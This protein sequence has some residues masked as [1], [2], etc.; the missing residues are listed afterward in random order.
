MTSGVRNCYSFF[1]YGGRAKRSSI[2]VLEGDAALK[3][4][5]DMAYLWR[6]LLVD[7]GV[8]NSSFK[9]SIAKGYSK[10]P[11]V[12]M[13]CR[14][15]FFLQV[16]HSF[17][18]RWFWLSS[19]ANSLADHLSRG[20]ELEF[21]KE[22]ASSGFWS[23]GATEDPYTMRHP[24]AG[25]RRTLASL[26]ESPKLDVATPSADVVQLHGDYAG[27]AP[28]PRVGGGARNGGK[29]LWLG[30]LCLFSL[31][32]PSAAMP[33]AGQASRRGGGLEHTVQYARSLLFDG[34][35]DEWVGRMQ[36]VMDMRLSASSMRTLEA[37]ANMAN[38]GKQIRLGAHY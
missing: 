13:I 32:S 23:A 27:R 29:C 36:D 33:S 2:M 5:E 30:V 35:P 3:C 38:C 34:L 31:C 28:S 25:D 7:F 6:G 16:Q 18:V 21:Q 8:D 37:G 15:W 26:A 20:R 12:A 11:Q 9:G 10:S 24:Q 17:L 14:R 1:Q 19:E 4:G 22:V